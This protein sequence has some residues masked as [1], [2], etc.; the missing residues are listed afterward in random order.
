MAQFVTAGGHEHHVSRRLRLTQDPHQLQPARK[1][2]ASFAGTPVPATSR[3]HDHE[4]RQRWIGA[5]DLCGY[6]E[7]LDWRPLDVRQHLDLDAAL[8]LLLQPARQLAAHLQHRRT[9]WL[10]ERVGI[11]RAQPGLATPSHADDGLVAILA[12]RVTKRTTAG[13]IW[14]GFSEP[15]LRVAAKRSE[16]AADAPFVR[17]RR[18][19]ERDPLDAAVADSQRAGQNVNSLK[20]ERF[21]RSGQT[22]LLR[23]L[24]EPVRGSA[25]DRGAGP[26]ESL[27]LEGMD[28][29][30]NT[31]CHDAMQPYFVPP[32]A[33]ATLH[34]PTRSGPSARATCGD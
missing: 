4:R 9:E 10:E 18:V 26:M 14:Y 6:V 11:A 5:R 15:D 21:E 25:I 28:D 13:S 12:P 22:G 32:S 31:V 1:A 27:F 33:V 17:E 16:P 23:F 7:G 20:R 3:R 34:T 24:A 29:P 19:K 30:A 2:S 8:H